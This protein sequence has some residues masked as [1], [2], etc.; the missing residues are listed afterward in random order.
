MPLSVHCII[1]LLT[2]ANLGKMDI[3]FTPCARWACLAGR[4]CEHDPLTGPPTDKDGKDIPYFL[5]DE[6]AMH[7][8]RTLLMDRRLLESMKYYTKFWLK[9]VGLFNNSYWN[10][11][12][13]S[14]CVTCILLQVICISVSKRKCCSLLYSS[15]LRPWKLYIWNH[16][17]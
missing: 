2:L 13:L 12:S 8:L 17:L 7:A 1:I 10:A 5:H 15:Q 16:H 3:N 4:Q 11:G 6:Q 14:Q 9:F